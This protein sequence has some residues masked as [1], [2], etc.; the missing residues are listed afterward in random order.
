LRQS[1]RRAML[2]RHSLTGLHVRDE[3]VDLCAVQR[4]SD[5]QHNRQRDHDIAVRV[6]QIARSNIAMR[7][8]G[9]SSEEQINIANSRACRRSPEG[10]SGSP[11]NSMHSAARPAI[12]SIQC[13]YTFP[14]NQRWH[15]DPPPQPASSKQGL[16]ER[17]RHRR[18][19]DLFDP[20]QLIRPSP[21]EMCGGRRST[22]IHEL[23]GTCGAG[24]SEVRRY[25]HERTHLV[26][27]R[28]TKELGERVTSHWWPGEW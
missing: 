2:D 24:C 4:P 3:L 11:S 26:A 16:H 13:S 7:D 27:L 28:T 8:E 17:L 14:K 6:Q 23:S 12:N 21:L 1:A 5:A 20:K 22:P 19:P 9:L 25:P 18:G 10:A 15:C